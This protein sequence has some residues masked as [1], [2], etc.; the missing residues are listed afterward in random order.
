MEVPGNL[1]YT[2][3]HEWV[4][5][6]GDGTARVGITHHAQDALGDIVYFEPPVEGTEVEQGAECAVIESV[7]AASEVYAPVGGEVVEVNDAV[8][9]SPELVNASPYDEGWLV[10]IRMND[11]AELDELMTAEEY[12]EFLESEG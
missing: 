1:K 9:D 12:R 6:Q 5:D 4:R 3:E 7:K 10:V 8:V 2:N 11:R